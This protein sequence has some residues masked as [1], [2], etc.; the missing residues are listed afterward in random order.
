MRS[1]SYG[2]YIIVLG[3]KLANL[4]RIEGDRVF[5]LRRRSC[6]ACIMSVSLALLDLQ[7]LRCLLPLAADLGVNGTAAAA[8]ELMDDEAAEVFARLI[9]V[10][11][12]EST[13]RLFLGLSQSTSVSRRTIVWHHCASWLTMR[14]H[15][16]STSKIQFPYISAEFPCILF[17]S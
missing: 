14:G 10:K 9:G 13:L 11:E 5:L 2:A 12:G 16:V 4:S 8:L 15:S 1:Q 6:R 3:S 17:G 7:V